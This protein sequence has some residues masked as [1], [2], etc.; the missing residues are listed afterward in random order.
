MPQNEG[1]D[2]KFLTG[3]LVG[4][5]LGVLIAVGAG[6]SFVFVR[7]QQQRQQVDRLLVEA[8]GMLEE[9]SKAKEEARQAMA[10]AE[11][12]EKAKL[13]AEMALEVKG[14]PLSWLERLPEPNVE[15]D[16]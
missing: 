1:G 5:F 2:S 12:A 4:F 9:T 6:G 8:A 14:P 13:K 7:T 16:G 3:L 15:K 10:Q 11:E